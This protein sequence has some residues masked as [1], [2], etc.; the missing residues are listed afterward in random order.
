MLQISSDSKTRSRPAQYNAFG[1]PPGPKASCPYATTGCGGCWQR[2]AKGLKLHTCY[3][4]KL[5]RARP[6]IGKV[7]DRNFALLKSRKTADAMAQD[8]KRMFEEFRAAE[9]ASGNPEPCFRIHWSGDLYSRNYA[10]ALAQAISEFPDIR[11]WMYTR[12][13]AFVV[14]ELVALPNLV[15]FLSADPCNTGAA[16]DCMRWIRRWRGGKRVRLAFMGEPTERAKAYLKRIRVKT[17]Y[18]PVD[19]G[20]M[21]R[22]G[23][24]VNKCRFCVDEFSSAVVFEVK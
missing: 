3:V 7:L 9:A 4:D 21:E 17:G 14:P 6:N 11:F 13:F 22:E 2:P 15:L 5:Q 10:V 16:I 1:L 20:K 12:S 18:C 23:A 8:L 19:S 24:C